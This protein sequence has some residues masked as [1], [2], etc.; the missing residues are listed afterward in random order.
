MDPKIQEKCDSLI[1]YYR[2]LSPMTVWDSAG[3]TLAAASL[4][5]AEDA[6]PD[7][8]RFRTCRQILRKKKGPFSSFRGFSETIL[9]CRMALN[10]NPEACL[11][12]IIEAEALLH[13]FFSG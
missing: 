8:E 4:C 6:V 5:M 2:A 11:D 13:G 7:P 3:I 1:T 10:E 12:R 9:C